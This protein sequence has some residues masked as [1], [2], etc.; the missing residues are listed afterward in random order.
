MNPRTLWACQYIV[1]I[2]SFMVTPPG[3][4]INSRAWADLLPSRA[5]G[6]FRGAGLFVRHRGLLR[7]VR[8]LC[9][10]V[11]YDRSNRLFLARKRNRILDGLVMGAPSACATASRLA[12]ASLVCSGPCSA[13]PSFAIAAQ[14]RATAVSRSLNFFTGSG[15]AGCSRSQ[16]GALP[17]IPP[18][19][20]P[21]SSD[22]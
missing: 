2:S 15:R 4:F 1:L 8:R 16:P 5:A 10:S 7:N 17:A 14:T 6:L 20:C 22:W 19:A 3:R 21:A 11:S 9:A 18:P 13:E 12:G